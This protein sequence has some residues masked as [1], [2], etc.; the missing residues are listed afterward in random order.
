[1]VRSQRH[2]SSL[3]TRRRLGFTLIELLV[4]IAI[5]AIL[6]ALLLPAV[7]QA[8]EAARRT[9]CRNHLKQ[10]GL[11]LH[12]YHD[13]HRCFPPGWIGVDVSHHM[14]GLNGFAWG[15]HLLPYLD[16]APLYNRLN[17]HA[18]C[19]DPAFNAPALNMV[20]PV[21]RCPTDPSPDYWN[22]PEEDDLSHILVRLPTANY[23]GNFGT[24]GPEELCED[25]PFPA[26][27]CEADGLFFHNSAI[28]ISDITDGTS[29]TLLLGEHRTDTRPFIT[30]H[31][32]AWHSTW[33]G[34]VPEGAEPVAR[35]LGV[36]D[37]TPNHPS[38]HIEDYSSWHTGG[39]H[40]LLTDGRVQF[41]TEN[42]NLGVWRA[43]ATRIGGE[44]VT[45]Y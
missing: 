38:L 19:W 33:V 2:S 6:I 28:K 44:T 14:E 7:Q 26:A 30:A 22:M 23:V 40:I 21:F 5:I 25:P 20:L 43:L 17:F 34:F 42:V 35:F 8:R 36:S 3:S 41:I 13:A 29:N 31:G 12:N 45:D 39:V 1:M 18:P 9:Q 32:P 16:Q 24:E 15:A 4:V 10:L 27:R 11:A 37:H